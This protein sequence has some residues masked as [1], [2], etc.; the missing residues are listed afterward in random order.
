MWNFAKK[1]ILN[2]RISNYGYKKGK[3]TETISKYAVSSCTKLTK[4]SFPKSL[5]TIEEHAFLKEA[6]KSFKS[7]KALFEHKTKE[8]ELGEDVLKKVKLI[9]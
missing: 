6:F 4:V 9:F 2:W 7:E 3:E 5:K 1:I 8:L